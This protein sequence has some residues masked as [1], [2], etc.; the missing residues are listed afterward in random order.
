MYFVN[1]YYIEGKIMKNIFKRNALLKLIEGV[2][3]ALTG[4]LIAIFGGIDPLKYERAISLS[5]AIFLF[6]D[7][8]ILFITAI[9]DRK[10]KIS[11]NIVTGSLLIAVGV[12]FIMSGINLNEFLPPF[13]SSI[14]LAIGAGE[15]AKG[16]VQIVQKEK[17]IWII[18]N[19]LIAAI[20]ITFGILSIFYN[21]GEDATVKNI[22]YIILGIA[23]VVAA[24][25]EIVLASVSINEKRKKKLEEKKEEE[26]KV[27]IEAEIIEKEEI[28]REKIKET[29]KQIE[30]KKR[31]EIEEKK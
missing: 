17:V 8:A 29:P 5:L 16:T 3:L 9:L 14:L 18:V 27:I 2:L 15:I 11:L 30:K 28:R 10:V 20:A 19:F 26:G 4:I 6:L 22:I 13:V 25:A 24:T 12:V 23:I 7:G 21:K 1:Y 31:K